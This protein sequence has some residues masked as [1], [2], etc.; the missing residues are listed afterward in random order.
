M[1]L[2]FRV[3]HYSKSTLRHSAIRCLTPLLI[4][5]YLLT[6]AFGVLPFAAIA[7]YLYQ[8]H[9]QTPGSRRSS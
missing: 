9:T 7:V 8:T 4:S 1:Y 5:L 6:I 3:L 2:V